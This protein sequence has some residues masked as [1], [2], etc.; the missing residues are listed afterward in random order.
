MTLIIRNIMLSHFKYSRFVYYL[1]YQQLSWPPA[2]FLLAPAEG[3]VFQLNNY[4][5]LASSLASFISWPLA[6]LHEVQI[7]TF[8]PK[9]I[10]LKCFFSS[11]NDLRLIL[12]GSKVLIINGFPENDLRLILLT[13]KSINLKSFSE[14]HSRLILFC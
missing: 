12:F 4:I 5:Q 2:S 3:C 6:S 10:N 13:Q 9:N 1:G 8:D 7:N 11:E 14:N